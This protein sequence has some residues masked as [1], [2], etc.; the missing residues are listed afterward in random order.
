[1]VE[2]TIWLTPMRMPQSRGADDEADDA[3]H[4]IAGREFGGQFLAQGRFAG[5]AGRLPRTAKEGPAAKAE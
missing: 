4:P 2:D 3:V 1:M 5:A